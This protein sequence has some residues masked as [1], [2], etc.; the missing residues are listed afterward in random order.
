MPFP[1]AALLGCA[2]LTGA[3]A[4]LN[5][6]NVR[7]GDSV[8]II[9]AGGVGINAVTGAVLAGA[10]TIIAVDVEDLRLGA[11]TRFGAT[12][13]I[14]SAKEDVVEAVSAITR[15]GADYVFDFVGTTAV[16]SSCLS[17]LAVGEDSI[18]SV[19]PTRRPTS[20]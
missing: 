14:N 11:A 12:H 17:M 3:G 6:A 4:V 20:G 2:V 19:S 8:V 9:G 7:A 1:Q 15:T 16:A 5:T 10:S 18:W 13:V